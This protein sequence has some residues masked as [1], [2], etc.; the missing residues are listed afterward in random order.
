ME[1]IKRDFYL[2]QIRPFIDKPIIKVLSGQRRVGKSYIMMQLS[3]EICIQNKNANIIYINCEMEEFR[4][5][6]NYKHLHDYVQSKIKKGS[7]NY[8][9]IDEVQ[10][11]DSFQNCLR[12]L[13]AEGVCDIYCTGSNAHIL[14]GELATFLSGRFIEFEIH[15]LSYL[16][17][18]EFHQ[19]ENSQDNLIKYLT[20]GGMPFL[21]HLDLTPNQ[22]FEYL[23]NVYSTILLKDVVEKEKIR[24]ISFLEN[25]VRYIS[26]N[27]G[28]L[29][30]ANNISKYLKSQQINMTPQLVL[31]Y[32]K[33]LTNSY[34]IHKVS[35]FEIGGLKIFEIGEKYYFEDLGIRNLLFGTSISSDI[36][37]I[38][39]NAIY[40]HLIQSGF[41]IY[42]GKFGSKEIDFVAEKNGNR[43]YVQ[44]AL[45]VMEEKTKNREFGNLMDIQDN[46]PKFVITLNDMIIGSDYFGIKHI[47]LAEFLMMKL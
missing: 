16:E 1:Y 26:N 3:D 46:Y 42:V 30:S 8:L 15:S 44:S 41:T 24:N 29:F 40:L 9:F 25:L 17:F 5:I 21:I 39:E 7:S 2:D 35:R 43:I 22:V 32:L 11:I 34:I 28:S 36:H 10:E 13:L 31:N 4:E 19:L 45:T 20:Y 37:K 47:N 12:S 27:I 23:K 6:N 14:S 38:M 33:G 18:L